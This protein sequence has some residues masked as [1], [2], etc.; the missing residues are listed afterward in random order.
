MQD[1]S[2]MNGNL[3]V[4]ISFYLRAEVGLYF[5]RTLKMDLDFDL[6]LN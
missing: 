2:L 6:V 3:S 1:Q 4:D 5:D